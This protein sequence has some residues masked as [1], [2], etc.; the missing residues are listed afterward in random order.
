MM[1]KKGKIPPWLT[2]ILGGVD[3]GYRL[4]FNAGRVGD[5]VTAL[6]S[7]RK[8]G[9]VSEAMTV[10][11]SGRF[12]QA[13][14]TVEGTWVLQDPE[15]KRFLAMVREAGNKL[16]YQR[17]PQAAIKLY[18]VTKEIPSGSDNKITVQLA[19]GSGSI[20]FVEVPYTTSRR[21]VIKDKASNGT[22]EKSPGHK[23]RV[24]GDAAADEL[25]S[26]SECEGDVEESGS[27]EEYDSDEGVEYESESES[28]SEEESESEGSESGDKESADSASLGSSSEMSSSP[29]VCSSDEEFKNDEAVMSDSIAAV[30]SDEDVVPRSK[31]R[32]RKRHR[33][34]DRSD[35]EDEDSGLLKPRDPKLTRDFELHGKASIEAVGAVVPKKAAHSRS[36]EIRKAPV[37][38]V[39]VIRKEKP[40]PAPIASQAPS[41]GRVRDKPGM[42]LVTGKHRRATA[43][44]TLAP[45]T[46]EVVSV[47]KRSASYE[48][49]APAPKRQMVSGS[50]FVRKVV[51]GI[52]N[53]QKAADSGVIPAQEQLK[54]MQRMELGH[55]VARIAACL[56]VQGILVE[57]MD[58]TQPTPDSPAWVNPFDV[59]K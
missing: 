39:T 42:K 6:R 32:G 4:K 55:D 1:S 12:V 43:P 44:I 13:P 53:V 28:E 31:Q 47:K 48:A 46:T 34:I 26:D 2:A 7:S 33:V 52:K 36:S 49:A 15:G 8:D 25:G 23:Q 20:D 11:L 56:I 50:E 54:S 16:K 59:Q 14:F 27:E 17:L 3:S 40:S 30:Q 9:K 41:G 19:D 24:V 45:K 18:P 5:K 10:V 29:P 35:S 21:P 22:V 51:E 38:V 57:P 58:V 37:Q